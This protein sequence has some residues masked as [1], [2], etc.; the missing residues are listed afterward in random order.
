MTY[1]PDDPT[2]DR[3]THHVQLRQDPPGHFSGTCSCGEPL[4]AGDCSTVLESFDD[5]AR[6]I[7]EQL[8]PEGPG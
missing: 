7:Q 6:T 8:D 3:T 5:H 4:S 1:W 2:F